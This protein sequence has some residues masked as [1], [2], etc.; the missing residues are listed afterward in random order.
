MFDVKI[1]YLP[2]GRKTFDIESANRIFEETRDYLT[3]VCHC[4]QAPKQIITSPDELGEVLSGMVSNDVDCIVYQM[5]TFADA[6]FIVKV[7]ESCK[8]PIV[9]WSVREPEIGG[10]L[11]LNSLTGGNSSCHA[12][13]YYERDFDFIYGNPSEIGVQAKLESKFAAKQ[14]HRKLA[15]LTVGVLGDH[16]P[17]FY[18]SGTDEVELHRKIGVNLH[19]IDLHRMFKEALELDEE[20]W[21]P[22]LDRA[23]SMVV[24]L[25]KSDES[26][27]KFAKF[28]TC[29]KQ[30]VDRHH[31]TATAVRCWPEFFAEL[32][33][34]ACSTLSQFIEDG[35]VSS[36][37]SDIHGAVTMFIQRE[38]SGGLPP[39]LG[40][41]V[42]LNEANNS[43]VFWHCGAGAYS[44]AHPAVGA[45]AGVQPNRKL[46]FALDFGLKPGKITISRLSKSFDG[47]RMLIM[48]GEALDEPQ[49]FTG[50]SVSVKLNGQADQIVHSLML[51]GFEPHYSI[52]YDDIVD[53]LKELCKLL[54]I[55]YVIFE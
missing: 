2:I 22:M 49:P 36:C 3:S 4:V 5:T 9:V 27:V 50:T 53:K 48:R 12:L 42:L 46:G 38:L 28:S 37:E 32:G 19:H 31:I 13:R 18:F 1:A 40:D 47:Y 10:R 16:P 17:G 8:Q 39:Y 25:D 7:M 33:A 52:I 35:I 51:G 43:V 34:A 20:A 6:E 54:K 11:R 30:Y 44:L 24:G 55:E 23:A 15:A 21:K 26:A 29:L 45:K 41:L 14:T